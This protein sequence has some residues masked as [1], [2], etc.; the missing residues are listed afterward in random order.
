MD[1]NSVIT[2]CSSTYSYFFLENVS[3]DILNNI[4]CFAGGAVVASLAIEVFPKAFKEDKYWTGIATALGLV[5]AFYLN[6][7][8]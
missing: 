8:A 1:G 2:F 6:S 3:K 7:L 5:I 4:R